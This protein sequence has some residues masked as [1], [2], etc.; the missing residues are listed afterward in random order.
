MA[1]TS[2]IYSM[3]YTISNIY[4]PLMVDVLCKNGDK[5]NM[6]YFRGTYTPVALLM[7]I[8]LVAYYGTKERL[9]LPKSR[10]TKM[11][12]SNSMRAVAG[13]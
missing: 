11:S 4:F 13:N 9:V 12:F 5:Y 1:I 7:P 3:G 2:I 8:V 6:R 10:I